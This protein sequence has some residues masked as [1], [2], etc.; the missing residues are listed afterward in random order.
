MAST[1]NKQHTKDFI[2]FHEQ[3]HRNFTFETINVS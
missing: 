3:F 1:W 2:S